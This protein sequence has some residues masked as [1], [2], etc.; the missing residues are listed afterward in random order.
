MLKILIA[1]DSSTIRRFVVRAIELA[2]IPTE[3]VEAEDGASC[4]EN[5]KSGKFDIALVDVNMPGLSG[6]DAVAKSRED[7]MD[8]FVVIMSTEQNPEKLQIARTLDVYE[9]LAKP[10]K[11]SDI[12]SLLD[13]YTRFKKPSSVLIV[14]D[15]STIRG[16]IKRV[17]K[18]SI[19]NLQVEDVADGPSGLVAYQNGNHDIVFLDL[20]MPGIS[21]LDTLAMLRKLNENLK[22]VLITTENNEATVKSIEASQI[23][24]V[25]YKPFYPVDVDRVLHS[26]FGLR[27]P[28]LDSEQANSAPQSAN[29]QR[30]K[31]VV[32]I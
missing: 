5:L 11:Q 29:E 28:S 31:Q 6:L 27:A 25:L 12:V 21:G 3:I 7:G 30:D 1:D 2:N 10:F 8:T 32:L 15:S 20:N 4:L 16:V 24:G 22:V 13:N 23:Q 14:D 9:Y 17:L 18:N 26:M 19:F